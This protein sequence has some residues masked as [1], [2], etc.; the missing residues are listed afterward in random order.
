MPRSLKNRKFLQFALQS[1]HRK[2]TSHVRF[3]MSVSITRL[4]DFT[5]AFNRIIDRL[6]EEE[7]EYRTD[8]AL[9]VD[10]LEAVQLYPVRKEVEA[11]VRGSQ[12]LSGAI[13]MAYARFIRSVRFSENAKLPHPE[14]ST[15][16]AHYIAEGSRGRN[17]WIRPQMAHSLCKQLGVSA[18]AHTMVRQSLWNADVMA[19][20][21]KAFFFAA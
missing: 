12:G 3:P 15:Y 11:L 19:E 13:I 21:S 20:R 7:P 17:I 1:R 10:P 9:L 14:F 8:A 2:A 18:A 4:P 5:I 16:F 6:V